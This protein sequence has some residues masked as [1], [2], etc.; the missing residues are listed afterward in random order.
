M[1]I[2]IRIIHAHDFVCVSASGT[3]NL[4]ASK[5]ALIEIASVPLPSED[6]ELILDTREAK[7][8]MSLTN[9][10]DLASELS[11][12]RKTFSRKMAILCPPDRFDHADFFALCA[13]VREFPVRIFVSFE[14]AI[15]WL[16]SDNA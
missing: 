14:D 13:R 3:F 6:F 12:L 7:I 2:N 15:E 5:Q 16:K 11:R 8:E 4:V 10:F 1:A 9:L